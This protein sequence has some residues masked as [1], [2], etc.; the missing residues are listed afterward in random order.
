VFP[1]ARQRIE[2]AIEAAI[3]GRKSPKQALDDAAKDVDQAIAVYNRTM[4]V[5]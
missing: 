2:E 1:E 3:L 4:G 5:A